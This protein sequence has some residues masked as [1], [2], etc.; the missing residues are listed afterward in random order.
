MPRRKN[1]A[2]RRVYKEFN[3]YELARI[4][5]LTPRQKILMRRYILSRSNKKGR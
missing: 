2:R 5:R 3:W 4:A 1:K